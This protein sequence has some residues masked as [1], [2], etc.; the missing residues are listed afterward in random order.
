MNSTRIPHQLRLRAESAY[1]ELNA[2]ELPHGIQRSV[3]R[4][5][6]VAYRRVNCLQTNTM[7]PRASVRAMTT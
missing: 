6:Y 3:R 4:T 7:P 2:P 5:R 1:G